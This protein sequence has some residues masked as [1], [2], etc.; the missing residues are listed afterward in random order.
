MGGSFGNATSKSVSYGGMRA[1]SRENVAVNETSGYLQ[2]QNQMQYSH[3]GKAISPTVGSIGVV[4]IP[5]ASIKVGP[6]KVSAGVFKFNV[7]NISR[8]VGF[9]TTSFFN[10]LADPQGNI[11]N[12]LT[13]FD[14]NS[15]VGQNLTAPMFDIY[16]Q[17]TVFPR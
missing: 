13:N 6:F 4:E 14:N 9:D 16:N 7:P 2:P 15:T 5:G 17:E 1:F 8:A 3:P 11:W 10:F 12:A